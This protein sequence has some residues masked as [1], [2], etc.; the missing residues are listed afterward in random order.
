MMVNRKDCTVLYEGWQMQCCGEPFSI[1]DE[2]E[3][4]VFAFNR[5]VV[6]IDSQID[7][8]YDAHYE[9]KDGLSILKGTVDRI[10][11]LFT[12]YEP[13]LDNPKMQIPASGSLRSVS[14]ADGCEEDIGELVFNSYFIILR[15]VSVG[16]GK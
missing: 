6:G 12:K 1:G 3:W 5:T 4:T 16:N 2:I 13:S 11:A 8:I 15:D 14:K 7:Y 9:T 10:D